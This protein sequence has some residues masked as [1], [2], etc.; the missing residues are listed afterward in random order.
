MRRQTYGYLPSH[1][2]SP[3]IGWY[4]IILLG[5]RGTRVLT[6]CPGLHSIAERPGFELATYWSQVQ[7]PNHSATK[8]HC[9]YGL[10]KI[11]NLWQKSPFIS[12]TV[13]DRRVVAMEHIRTWWF[14]IQLFNIVRWCSVDSVQ[15]CVRARSVAGWFPDSNQLSASS[16]AMSAPRRGLEQRQHQQWAGADVCRI[17][18]WTLRDVVCTWQRSVTSEYR[19]TVWSQGM[20]GGSRC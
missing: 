13:R 5:G 20:G 19:S 16:T 17:W 3:P 11:C 1:K 14:I 2:A 10:G 15:L 12:E 9:T 8:P 18:T 4:Q 7:H 6:T